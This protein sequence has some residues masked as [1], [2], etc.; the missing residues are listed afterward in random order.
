MDA[1]AEARELANDWDYQDDSFLVRKFK[2]GSMV[3]KM[4]ASKVF[5]S[6][7]PD[8]NERKEVIRRLS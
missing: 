3:E 2:N 8:E 6:R 7:Y 5:T 4:A 1:T